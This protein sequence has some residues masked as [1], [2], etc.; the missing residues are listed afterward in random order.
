MLGLCVLVAHMEIVSSPDVMVILS[1]DEPSFGDLNPELDVLPQS[2][3]G[4]RNPCLPD[5]LQE[6]W[7]VDPDPQ[8]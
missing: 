7:R 2:S 1:V 3:A 4:S 5:I 8:G 6:G